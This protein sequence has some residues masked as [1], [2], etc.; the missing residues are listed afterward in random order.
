MQKE[1][2]EIE[3]TVEEETTGVLTGEDGEGTYACEIEGDAEKGFTVTNTHTPLTLD[4]EVEK[5]WEDDD[6]ADEARPESVTVR[7]K[8]NGKEVDSAALD[9]DGEWK[10]T[11]EELPKF[12]NGKAITYTL[13]EDSI[14]GYTTEI[15]GDAETGFTVTNTHTA[16]TWDLTQV[17]VTKVWKDADN[18]DGIRPESVNVKLFADGEDTGKTLTLSEE[19]SWTGSFTELAA[20]TEAQDGEEA[21]KIVY[22]VEEETTEVI[23]GQDGADTYAVETKGDAVK[24]FTVK[25]THTPAEISIPVS[26]IWSDSNDSEHKRPDS[27]TIRLRADRKEVA[28]RTVTLEDSWKTEFTGLPVYSDG[29]EI[30]YTVTEDAVENYL[31]EISGSAGDGFT[32]TNEYQPGMTTLTVM[33]VWDDEDNRDGIRPE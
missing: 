26:K 1:D 4:V 33:K 28:S 7:L 19:N 30:E 21:R 29:K 20:K 12:K 14:E 32:I 8:A 6:N 24:G 13:T 2:E 25:N 3:Y 5:V 10:K 22:T 16:E 17:S 9:E 23:T 11:F 31:T 27:I 15:K 18:Q